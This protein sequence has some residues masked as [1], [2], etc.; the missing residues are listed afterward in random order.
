MVY[1]FQFS[2]YS[3]P[4]QY[5]LKTYH[6]TWK[7][8]KGILL[9]LTNDR[10]E[11]GWGEIA[12]LSWF[13]SE[14]FKQAVTF[15]YQ[16]PSK[17][18]IETILTIPSQLPACQFGFESALAGIKDQSDEIDN[19]DFSGLLPTGKPALKTWKSLYNR[20]YRTLKWKI[21][22]QPIKEELD[23]F[24]QLIDKMTQTVS[25]NLDINPVLLRL[26]ANGSLTYNMA[27][28]WLKMCDIL[29]FHLRASNSVKI[30]FIEQ[31]LPI[32]QFELMVKLSD[33]Y[34]TPIALDESVATF[35]QLETCCQQGWP[36]IFVIKPAIIGS[37]RKLRKF[38]RNYS[39]DTVFSSVFETLIGQ[40]Y[41]LQLATEL[42]LKNRAVGFGVQHWFKEDPTI[43][44]EKVKQSV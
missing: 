42:S 9:R 12:P 11:T 25:I 28:K 17:I 5:P 7:T 44:L 35:Q 26:D 37:P 18:T 30:E 1:Q 36:G 27:R 29:N 38:C 4:F 39:L 31:P 24:Q 15:C 14:T 43:W 8:R 13:G 22:V 34:S 23:I 20:G 19:L 10:G 40:R 6:G 33:E 3:R 21:G 32:S 16:L 41:S 2:A